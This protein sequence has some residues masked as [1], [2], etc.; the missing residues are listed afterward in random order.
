MPRYGVVHTSQRL[1]TH[2]TF[3]QPK[4]QVCIGLGG[5]NFSQVTWSQDYQGLR[6]SHAEGHHCLH[7]AAYPANSCQPSRY[8]FLAHCDTPR[9]H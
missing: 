8:C 5:L 7:E 6:G 2:I 1:L 4:E 9:E 3:V